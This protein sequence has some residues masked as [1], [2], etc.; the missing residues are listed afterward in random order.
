VRDGGRV[1]RAILAVLACVFA[2]AASCAPTI[3]QE[4]PAYKNPKLSIEQ[5]VADLLARMT[6]EE[7]LAQIESA[8]GNRAFVRET[9]PFLA[10]EKGAFL[11]ERAQITLKN[12]LGQVS[13]PSEYPGVGGGPREM[14][15]L[16]NAIQKWVKEN[17]RLEFQSCSTKSACMGTRRRRVRH[18]QR[19]LDSRP[20]GTKC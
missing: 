13:R 8:W 6:I 1:R 9:Q 15:E 11:P 4:V 18:F 16:T 7:K 10:D 3:A 19:R 14:A 5:R 12:G 17:T 2:G 20:H